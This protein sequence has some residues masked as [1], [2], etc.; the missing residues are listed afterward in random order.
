MFPSL[1]NI[2]R[3]VVAWNIRCFLIF[4]FFFFRIHHILGHLK[5]VQRKSES[6]SVV[7]NSLWLHGLYSPWDSPGQNTGVGSL[8]LLQGIF[9]TRDRT[10]VSH[11]TGRFFTS[12]ATGKVILYLDPMCDHVRELNMTFKEY[13]ALCPPSTA[14]RGNSRMRLIFSESVSHSVMSFSFLSPS[15]SSVHGIFQARILE[16]VAIPFSRRSSWPRDRTRVFSIEGRFFTIWAT[17]EPWPL[18]NDKSKHWVAFRK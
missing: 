8:S 3:L 6:H 17:R 7:S 16:W 2:L 10:Q 5:V 12:W 14:M 13:L 15:G 11:I 1:L 18:L 4:F 9:P